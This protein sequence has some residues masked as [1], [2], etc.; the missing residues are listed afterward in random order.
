MNKD[1]F[2]EYIEKNFDIDG[3]A[4]RLISNILDYVE[5][6]SKDTDDQYN[7]LCDLLDGTIGLSD[8]EIRKVCL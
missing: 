3:A 4:V 1:Q 5:S 6:N 7:M 2:I 8:A